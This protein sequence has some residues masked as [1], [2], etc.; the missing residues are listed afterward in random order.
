M[1]L[2]SQS[3]QKQNV[4]VSISI[5]IVNINHMRLSQLS[6]VVNS[7]KWFTAEACED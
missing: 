2:L 1:N 6:H 4:L 5:E 3:P 7:S